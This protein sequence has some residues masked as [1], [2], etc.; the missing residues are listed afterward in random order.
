MIAWDFIG[1]DVENDDAR[2]SSIE[3][4]RRL[5]KIA[6]RLL[7]ILGRQ[8]SSKSFPSQVNGSQS[9][10]EPSMDPEAQIS[11]L[12]RPTLDHRRVSFLLDEP[13]VS[14]QDPQ[15][16]SM[17]EDIV[18]TPVTSPD[19]TIVLADTMTILETSTVVR[20][21]GAEEKSQKPSTPSPRPPS[22]HHLTHRHRVSKQGKALLSSL[23]P[24]P[25]ISIIIS[26]TIALVGPLKALFV[27]VPN[28]RIPNAPPLA[29]VQDAA[30]FIGA[31]SVPLGLMCL[32]SALARLKV[33]RNQWKSLPVGA[34]TSLAV[35]KILLTPVILESWYAKV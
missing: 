1:P 35:G 23:V 22:L 27:P 10:I 20:E 34:I 21:V 30:T 12:Q 4:R 2:K 7:R 31:A 19:P 8:T 25:S 16:H 28:S 9:G 11:A 24:P 3:K 13:E 33:P 29:F 32:G 26:F 5:F 6:H 15:P 18:L 17:S 14:L